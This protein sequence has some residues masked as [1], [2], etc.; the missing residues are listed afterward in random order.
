[1]SARIEVPKKYASAYAAAPKKDKG[2]ILNQVVEVTGW[3]RDHARQQ[4]TARLRQPPGRASATI[5]VIDK[6]W[7]EMGFPGTA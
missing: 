3:N 2:R 5:A 7:S 6:R 4:L 1:M